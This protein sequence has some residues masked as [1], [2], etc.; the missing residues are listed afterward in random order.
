MLHLIQLLCKQSINSDELFD[1][2]Q[3]FKLENPPYVSGDNAT[4][5][6]ITTK[7]SS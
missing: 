4:F 2:L 7:S 1:L 5:T 6:I 3:L